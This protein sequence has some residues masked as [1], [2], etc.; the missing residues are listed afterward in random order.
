[1]FS[2]ESLRLALRYSFP[3]GSRTFPALARKLG[4]PEAEVEELVRFRKDHPPR[5]RMVQSVPWTHLVVGSG[6]EAVVLL[7]GMAGA[8][9]V[10]WRVLPRLARRFRVLS[11]TYPAVETVEAL[12]RGV[13]ALM[14]AYGMERATV[15][16]SSLG[17]Y[18][19]QYLMHHAAAR[20]ARVVLGNTF[21]P[22]GREV[23]QRQYGLLLRLA[24][25]LPEAVVLAAFRQ[26]YFFK[27]HPTSRSPLLLAYLL[28]QSYVG[29][30]KRDVIARG[31][32]VL[33]APRLP[34]PPRHIPVLIVES[35]ND[36]LIPPELRAAL[37]ARYPW[38][39]VYTFRDAGHFPY[40][41]QP[42]VYMEVLE[43]FLAGGAS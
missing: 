29:M 43:G 8:Y 4:V 30:R 9:D 36:P 13:L 24:P 35:A 7:H 19:A 33:Y 26:G 25:W 28:E 32:C 40:V 5:Q 23:Y 2:W 3:L 16:G 34:E 6:P 41:N 21:P 15:V 27:V 42:A 10:W 14:D 12:A 11:V 39:Q 31:R 17:G 18:V 20:V 37:K 22:E 38:A 1:M